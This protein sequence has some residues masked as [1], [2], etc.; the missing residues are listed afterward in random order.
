MLMAKPE[1]DRLA[2]DVLPLLEAY[3]K[4]EHHALLA[5]VDQRSKSGPLS[6][7]TLG[8]AAASMIALERYDEAAT[9]ARAAVGQ[10]PRTAWLY[11][12]LSQAER[13]RGDRTQAL[14]A[15]RLAA[16]LLPGQPDYLATLAACQRESGDAKQ[17][18]ATA[19]QAVA[20]DD[21]N[22]AALNQ[23]GLAL[24]ATGDAAGAL[25]QFRRAQAA[26]P[27]DPDGYLNEGDLHHGAGRVREARRAYQEAL[28][29]QLAVHAAEERLVATL[30]ESPLPRKALGHLVALSRLTVTGWAIVA[31]LYYLLFRLLEYLWRTWVVLIPAG[32][33]LLIVTLV[34]LLGGALLGRLL[35]GYLRRA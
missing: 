16:Q 18:L 25:E 12:I 34:W 31:F 20:T 33:V 27:T 5:E 29:R 19:W 7:D 10:Q 32:R 6:A 1:M 23:L 9:A 24:A 8:L 35:R 14:E 4:S 26:C 21:T 2:A 30:T 13:G 11:H 3:Q 17:A 22:A 28:R 15:A